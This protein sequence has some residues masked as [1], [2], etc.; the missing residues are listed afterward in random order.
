MFIDKQLIFHGT[1][2]GATGL[3]GVFTAAGP[4]AS[5][6]D[7]SGANNDIVDGEVVYAMVHIA[8]T[9][10]H[11]GSMTA[12]TIDFRSSDNA[13]LTSS[14]IVHTAR[15]ILIASLVANK[16]YCIGAV[17]VPPKSLQY[18]GF[19]FTPVGASATGGTMTCFLVKEPQGN[20]GGLK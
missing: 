4:S 16:T 3:G 19:Y 11:G 2:F 15:T 17:K 5:Q 18:M 9:F 6:L 1:G 13:S 10:T 12:A 7:R 20:I 14:P 8:D